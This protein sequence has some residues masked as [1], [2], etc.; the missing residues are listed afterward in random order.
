MAEGPRQA[1]FQLEMRQQ[2]SAYAA[3]EQAPAVGSAKAGAAAL[4]A[5]NAAHADAEVAG[6]HAKVLALAAAINSTLGASVLQVSKTPSWPRSWA[7]SR[8]LWLYSRRN[9]WLNW[10][11]LGQPNALLAAE[12]GGGPRPAALRHAAQRPRVHRR[13]GVDESFL[14]LSRSNLRYIQNPYSYKK[15]Q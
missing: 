8:L 7:N 1:R 11:L 4:A 15:C 13:R 10:H 6:W 3:L 2:E 14:P 5:L 9:A 12:P